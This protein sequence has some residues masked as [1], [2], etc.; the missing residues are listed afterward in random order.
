MDIVRAKGIQLIFDDPEARVKAV[1]EGTAQNLNS[2]LQDIRAGRRTENDFI[3]GA[4]ARE[5]E[6]IGIPATANRTLALLIG[7]LETRVARAG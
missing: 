6:R 2:M 4:V 3:N 1:C 5:G 7:A